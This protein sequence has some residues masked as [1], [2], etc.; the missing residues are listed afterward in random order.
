MSID[1]KELRRLYGEATPGPWEYFPEGEDQDEALI[2]T[3]HNALPGLLDRADAYDRAVEWARE[4]GCTSCLHTLLDNNSAPCSSCW[5]LEW[6][7][8]TPAWGG[9]KS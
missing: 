9:E 7:N 2:S 4:M 3:M 5:H 1:T 6:N 8:W